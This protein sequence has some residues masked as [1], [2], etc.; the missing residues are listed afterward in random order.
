MITHRNRRE[1]RESLVAPLA[2]CAA[3]VS[4]PSRAFFHT[5]TPLF[6]VFR[7]FFRRRVGSEVTSRTLTEIDANR[8]KSFAAPLAETRGDRFLAV[9]R[10][11][12]HFTAYFPRFPAP[13]RHHVAKTRRNRAR[14]VHARRPTPRRRFRRA[15]RDIPHTST[16]S[17][18]FLRRKHES[19]V[20][21]RTLVEIAPKSPRTRV[22]QRHAVA[23]RRRARNATRF[24]PRH[25][26]GDAFRA[27]ITPRHG[28]AHETDKMAA[29]RARSAPPRRRRPRSTNHDASTN[30]RALNEPGR[31]CRAPRYRRVA[32]QS[33]VTSRCFRVLCRIVPRSSRFAAR[34]TWSGFPPTSPTPRRDL[35]PRSAPLR[36]VLCRL[37]FRVVFRAV[38]CSVPSW[39]VPCCVVECS[40]TR[41]RLTR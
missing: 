12:R 13:F 21:S 14:L 18:R 35:A 20:M 25:R 38:S 11:V 29:D 10:A 19:E 31:R 3:T 27:Q 4:S 37:V 36:R 32:A 17:T 23:R 7:H 5:S 40:G 34:G 15:S 6:R 30:E 8:A 41:E 16:R 28:H 39:S 1:S 22:I 33:P 9:P 2:V 26:D 24:H